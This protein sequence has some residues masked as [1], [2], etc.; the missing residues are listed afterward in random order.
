MSGKHWSKAA[1]DKAVELLHNQQ[2]RHVKRINY[3][4]IASQLEEEE[5]SWAF[6]NQQVRD[7][8]KNLD[9]AVIKLTK[10]KKD[11][12]KKRKRGTAFTLISPSPLILR[13]C[14]PVDQC[15]F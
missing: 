6:T 2:K 15:F 10:S 3:K 12:K 4:L 14:F 11:K 7:H 13:S 8:I 1:S 5:K 9:P